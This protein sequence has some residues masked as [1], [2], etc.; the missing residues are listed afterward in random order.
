MR[1]LPPTAEEQA[2]HEKMT[3]SMRQLV[4][5]LDA[6]D[7]DRDRVLDFDEVRAHSRLRKRMHANRSRHPSRTHVAVLHACARARDGRAD[8]RSDEGAL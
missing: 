2:A 1:Y 3:I 5:D 4:M 8:R 6:A 7:S